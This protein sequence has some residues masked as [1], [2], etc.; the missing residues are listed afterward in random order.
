MSFW[1]FK[2]LWSLPFFKTKKAVGLRRLFCFN[3]FAA[4]LPVGNPAFKLLSYQLKEAPTAPAEG[5]PLPTP[6]LAPIVTL[7]VTMALPPMANAC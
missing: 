4:G 1:F 2:S 7:S 5:E 6:K 3:L